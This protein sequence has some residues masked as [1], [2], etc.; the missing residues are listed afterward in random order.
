MAEHEKEIQTVLTLM[1]D[2]HLG[3]LIVALPAIVS[4]QKRFQHENRYFVFDSAFREL[5][6]PLIDP[7]CTIFYPRKMANEGSILARMFVYFKF[8]RQIKK[9]HPDITVDLEGG[10]TSAILTQVSR[11]SRSFSRSNAER[12]D[13][14]TDRVVWAEGK[15]KIFHYNAI[16][17]AAGASV[18]EGFFRIR[19]TDEKRSIV[20]KKLADAGINPE[21]PMICLHPGGGRKQK[22][23]PIEGFIEV[24]DWFAR[25]DCQVVLIGGEREKKKTNQIIER[26]DRTV[27]NFAGAFSLGELLALFEKKSIF[28]GSDSG[29]MHMAAA[30]GSA[31][32]ALFSYADETEW[33]PRSERAVVLR[34]QERCPDCN[35]KDCDDP[36]CINTLSPEVVKKAVASFLESSQ[37]IP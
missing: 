27:T 14:Y 6:E 12:P 16:A 33:G 34:G 3:N 36:R 31:V 22:L 19:A 4:L 17:A 37:A 11:A 24:A 13:V 2:S 5:V 8:L 7:L 18:D 30:A 26:L 9:I 28:V 21:Q 32:V 25:Q 15:H 35:K 20:E 23:W 10:S 29:T 1:P